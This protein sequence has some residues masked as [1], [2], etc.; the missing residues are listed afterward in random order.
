MQS[1]YFLFCC[2]SI[3]FMR[4]KPVPRSLR[5]RLRKITGKMKSRG[6]MQRVFDALGKMKNLDF[7]K[8]TD[9][10]AVQKIRV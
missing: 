1:Q 9:V 8:D 10:K 7:R 4:S 6:Q 3:F 5:N 2:A